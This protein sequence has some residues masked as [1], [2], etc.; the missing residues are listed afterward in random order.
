MII[1]N[2]EEIPGKP[3]LRHLGVVQGST[4]QTK[5]L[6]RDFGAGLKN[7]IGGELKS[8]TALMNEAR[9]EAID[10]MTKEATAIGANA[11]VNVRFATST[12]TGGAAEILAYGTAVVIEGGADD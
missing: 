3:V 1:S 11:I 9:K 2:M 8:Y 10:R 12:I 6:F 5:N 4:V 7:L